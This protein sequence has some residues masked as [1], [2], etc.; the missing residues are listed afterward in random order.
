MDYADHTSEFLFE[1]KGR[2]NLGAEQL[3]QIALTMVPGVGPQTART[4]LAY[5]GSAQ[6]I[7]AAKTH[8]LLK[9]PGIG[10]ITAK[11][12]RQRN[13]FDAAEKEFQFVQRHKVE[14]VFFAD[15][16]YPA[17]LREV[18]DS[19]LL[20]YKH[21]KG[22]LNGP[23]FL[24][25][26]GSRNNT[27]YGAKWTHKVVEALQGRNVVVV[28]GLAYGIDIIAHRACL[29]F[30]IPTIGVLGHGLDRVY[31]HSHRKTAMQMLEQGALVTEFASGTIP[32]R[33]NFPARN[34]V[35]AGMCDATLVVEAA[36][37]G[38]ALITGYFAN[39]YNRDVF[40]IPGKLD[41]PYSAGCNDLIKKHKAAL[42][43]SVEDFEYLLGWGLP[44]SEAATKAAGHQ[45]KLFIELDAQEAEL[46]H[47]FTD[48]QKLHIEQ[49]CAKSQWPVSKVLTV[50][51]GLELKGAVRSLPG[52]MFE[53][54]I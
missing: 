25:I 43:S 26:V 28:S 31:P 8:Q 5:C 27:D 12:L 19:P 10:E 48:A 30:D 7:F 45:T 42:F 39:D 16:N 32:D 38:G 24:A 18:P 17:R 47:C 20:L 23:R 35:V 40:A 21:G 6:E 36:E 15:P 33:N 13:F 4:L 54:V 22:N 49:L 2:M 46:A 52:K 29:Q 9:I 53:W 50:L 51:M 1:S 11:A 14:L 44:E 3:H 41:D 37:K 34:R